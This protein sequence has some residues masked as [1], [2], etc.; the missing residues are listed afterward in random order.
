M[1][2]DTLSAL[3]LDDDYQEVLTVHEAARWA[4]EHPG[5]LEVWVTLS[6]ASASEQLFQARLLWHQY[7]DEPPSLK[8]RDPT[9]GRLD[10]LKAW[11]QAPGFRPGSFDACVPWTQEG[12]NVHPEWQNDARYRWDPRG[13]ALLKIL[14]ILQDELDDHFQGRH[15]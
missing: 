7:P 3:N 1:P 11:P 5:P 6:P 4:L 12:M 14:R 15:P 2:N 9:T 8:F 13:N 10:V